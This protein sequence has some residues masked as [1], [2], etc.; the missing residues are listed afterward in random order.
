MVGNSS[1]PKKTSDIG[2][3]LTP[4]EML[5]RNTEKAPNLALVSCNLP[6]KFNADGISHSLIHGQKF[7]RDFQENLKC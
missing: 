5:R 7:V 6:N 3:N 2:L 4:T 1:L